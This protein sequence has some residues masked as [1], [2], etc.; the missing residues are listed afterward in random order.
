MG[1]T[2][3][4]NNMNFRLPRPVNSPP[5]LGNDFPTSAFPQVKRHS[6]NPDAAQR[7]NEPGNFNFKD[8]N[9]FK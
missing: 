5:I 6:S 4:A 7:H 2:H 3:M 8:I 9:S 1:M